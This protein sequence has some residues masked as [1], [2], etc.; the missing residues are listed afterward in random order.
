[1]RPALTRF[2]MLT[3][4]ACANSAGPIPPYDEVARSLG[5]EVATADGGALVAIADLANLA[6]GGMPDGFRSTP[7]GWI[8]GSHDGIHYVYSV[9]CRDYRGKTLPCGETTGSVHALAG[10][11]GTM[12]NGIT[13]WH[14]SMWDLDGLYGGLGTAHS[15]AWAN[16]GVN[17]ELYIESETQLIVDYG[18]AMPLAGS[19]Q[20]TTDVIDPDDGS[21]TLTLT[22]DVVFDLPR[23]PTIMLDDNRYWLD[24]TTGEVTTATVLE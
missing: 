4:G 20:A 11:G 21:V 12:P 9:W 16:Y 23:R 22:G 15:D 8:L 19:I 1:M 7:Y 2:A 3:F 14:Q 13:V 18:N 17:G 24:I 6:H 10:W 5:A